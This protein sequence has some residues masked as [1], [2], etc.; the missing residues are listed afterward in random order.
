MIDATMIEP[1]T[2]ESTKANLINA[3]HRAPLIL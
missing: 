2:I 1:A 3:P